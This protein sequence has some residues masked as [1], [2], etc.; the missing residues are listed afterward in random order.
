MVNRPHHEWKER[1]NSMAN[2]Q[3]SSTV[4][5]CAVDSTNAHSDP[6]SNAAPRI[7][8][9]TKRR[10]NGAAQLRRRSFVL[11]DLE[12]RGAFENR[13]IAGH[14]EGDLRKWTAR[15]CARLHHRQ[16]SSVADRRSAA[17]TK[18][19]SE[20]PLCLWTIEVRCKMGIVL[21]DRKPDTEAST[22]FRAEDQR[23][24]CSE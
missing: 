6:V 13:F 21:L 12:S 18:A 8:E 5:A 7:I 20:R 1:M 23:P 3:P 4:A 24:T 14:L 15:P 16:A 11:R 17:Q 9:Q 19:R 22:F 10:K 2:P